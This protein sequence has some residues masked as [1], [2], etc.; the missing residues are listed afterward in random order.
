MLLT[1]PRS[2]LRRKILNPGHKLKASV[3]FSAAAKTKPKKKKTKRK[4]RLKNL[5]IPTRSHDARNLEQ[6]KC[7]IPPCRIPLAFSHSRAQPPLTPSKKDNKIK[8][9]LLRTARRCT[10][11]WSSHSSKPEKARQGLQICS[12]FACAS[13][14]T[15]KS[16]RAGATTTSEEDGKRRR[17]FFSENEKENTTLSTFFAIFEIKIITLA[18]SRLNHFLGRHL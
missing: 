16:R 2:S 11:A 10:G 14:T 18:T 6:C 12:G 1:K 9:K 7:K 8:K 17:I 4:S 3:T 13:A 5:I 15:C